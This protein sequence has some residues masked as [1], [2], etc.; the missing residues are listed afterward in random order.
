M[1]RKK[2]HTTSK[3]KPNYNERLQKPEA[4]RKINFTFFIK[5]VKLTSSS[6]VIMT[7]VKIHF[8]IHSFHFDISVWRVVVMLVVYR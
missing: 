3:S 4:E 8:N 1:T 5:S 6:Y 7:A 2:K